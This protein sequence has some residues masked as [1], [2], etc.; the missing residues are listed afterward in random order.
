QGQPFLFY[1]YAD[2]NDA[3]DT[4]NFTITSLTCSSNPWSISTVNNSHNATGL[5]N[6]TTL[7]N[8][9]V[10]C[11]GASSVRITVI[12]DNGAEDYQD[13]F[14]NISNTNDPPNIEVLSS[15][16]NNT[17][18]NNITN[19]VA[20]ADS[21]FIYIVNATDIDAYT[22]EGEVL[23][24]GDNSTF[25]DI[26]PGTGV[27]SFIPNQSLVGNHTLL[28]NVSDD[29]ELSDT[30]I[31]NIEVINNSAPVLMSIG[32]LSCAEDGL[33]FFVINATDYD[34]DDLNF[35]SNNTA[36]FSLT[37]NASQSPIAS[38]YVNYTPTQSNVGAYSV[39]V[40]VADI[41][42]ATD[43]E[44]IVFTINNTNDDP[45]IQSF[46]FPSTI[47]EAHGVS[48]YFQAD[49][50]DYG[51]AGVY[52]Y[53][54]FND[55]N[56]TG[57]D[58]F[59]ISTILNSTSNKT[60]AQII[61]TPGIGDAGNYSVNITATDY[62]GAVDWVVKN[63]T[64]QAK[65]NPPNI[66]QVMPYGAPYSNTT[67]FN[68]TSTSNYAASSTSI[69]FSENRSVIYNITVT[70][71][72][73]AQGS[74]SFGWY[75][76]GVLN[77][78]ASYLNLSYS[79]FSSGVYNITVF[80]NDD[81]YENSSWSW[82]LTVEDIN[83]APLFINS[84]PNITLN[85]TENFGD[86]LKWLDY[87]TN[88]T[89]MDP[90]DDPDSNNYLDLTEESTLNYNVTTCSVATITITGDSVR[91]VPV[92]V[93]TCTVYFT[94][95]D[96]GSLSNTSNAVVIN[97]S[98]VPNATQVVTTPEAS[99]SGGGGG[100]SRSIMVPITKQEELPKAIEIIVPELVTIYKNQTVLIPVTLQN[101]WN[102]SL[103]GIKV[104]ASTNASDVKLEFSQDYFESLAVGERKNTTLMISNYR[105]GENYE[106]KLIA[107]V[108]TPKA[109]DSALVILNSIEQAETGAEVETKVTFA[110]DLLSDNPECSE[111]N[112]LLYEAKD[113]LAAGETNEASK[114]V[115][116][117][118]NGCKYLV[119]VSKKVEQKPQNIIT[120]LIN[121]E[122]FK[123]LLIL[124]G[125]LMVG[126]ISLLLLKKKK[127]E[128]VQGKEK[129]AKKEEI[130]PYW[131]G[132]G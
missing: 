91:I 17:G 122:N 36:V 104:N 99:S 48:L 113:K 33:C 64:V 61:F 37:N 56:V 117:V 38:A 51:L 54:S 105:L 125:I 124:G 102:S 101:N 25:F 4:L 42:G 60:Y 63:F 127:T 119:S 123:N 120:R 96:S 6:I 110:Q 83:R 72:T 59:N 2:D 109:S 82:I 26:G 27:I 92:E 107:N 39:V 23:T 129:E 118:I 41:R 115:D 11:S 52:E 126:V 62:Y 100:R 80:V 90:D 103:L 28:I 84:L 43:T 89:F 94:A 85:S 40:T 30:Q 70:D 69:N 111:L 131:P 116:G 74:L 75:I 24:Y 81:T 15:Y 98:D 108:T 10:I 13:V 86:Y 45:E 95:Y 55:T 132:Q 12:D 3:N 114:M 128:A 87:M 93:G 5:V 88:M 49:D 47:V 112:E 78:T 66:T 65:T 50:E 29:G 97:V 73:T 31:M 71:D 1:V 57:R 21:I 8:D 7:T 68:F 130:K 19:L 77:S 18:G 79:F 121:E 67:F 22:Y 32:S 35:T 53:V 58:L 46:S 34:N 106:V 14:L 76:G 9:H 16:S 44:A 20:Y